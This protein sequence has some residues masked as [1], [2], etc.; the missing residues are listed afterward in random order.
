MKTI[1]NTQ[2]WVVPE[3]VEVTIKGRS[4][5]V[6]GPR[7]ELSK[8]FDHTKVDLSQSG[9]TVKAELW[10]GNKKGNACI[11]SVLS[12][13]KNMSTGVTKG[14]QYKMRMVYAHFPINVSIEAAQKEV[15]VRNFL[16]E[17]VVRVVKIPDGVTVARGA[18]VKDQIILEGNSIGDVSQ[19]AANLQQCTT[20]RNKD[21]R[22]F[23]DGIYVSERGNIVQD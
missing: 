19:T 17:K 18:D 14:Y 11:R 4:V 22:K 13:I 12:H 15:Q 6:K 10:W 1:L 23:L 9:K 8:N 21:I 2:T 20:A 3:G 7:G 16:G 5:T